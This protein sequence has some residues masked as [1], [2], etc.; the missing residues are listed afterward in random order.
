[1]YEMDVA[2]IMCSCAV[3]YFVYNIYVKLNVD[4][5]IELFFSE[6]LLLRKYS[7]GSD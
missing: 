2:E 1:M 5:R 7:S 4:F 3:R 6:Y